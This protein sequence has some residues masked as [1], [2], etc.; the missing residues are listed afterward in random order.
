MLL[1]YTT[2]M[3]GHRAGDIAE[4]WD[5]AD[6]RLCISRGLAV[7]ASE[8]EALRYMKQQSPELNK[9]VG[10]AP[11]NKAVKRPTNKRRQKK[12]KTTQP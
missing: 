1:K 2:T 6:A 5:V 3:G 10:L 7:L 9:M 12:K 11:K 8:D 4:V